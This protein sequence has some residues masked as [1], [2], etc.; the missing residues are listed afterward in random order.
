MVEFGIY[1]IG[2]LLVAA[3]TVTGVIG[4]VL[5]LG[6]FLYPVAWLAQVLGIIHNTDN[7]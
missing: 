4:F 2:G 7:D 1:L 6:A 5:L 3:L